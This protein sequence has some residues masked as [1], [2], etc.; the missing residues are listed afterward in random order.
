MV[1][2]SSGCGRFVFKPNQEVNAAQQQV[3]TLTQQNQEY[4]VR[5][6]SLDSD[7]QELESILAQSRQQIQLLN[8][9]LVATRGQLKSSTEQLLAA[10]DQNKQLQGKTSALLAS[11]Q[12]RAGAKIRSNNSLLK[13]LQV[14][15]IPG[16]E[17]RQ[18][19]DVIRVEV[20]A[21]MIFIP[22]SQNMVQGAEQLLQN[23][24]D[25]L[26]RNFPDQIIGIEGHTDNNPP[27][28]HQFSSNHHLS[29]V[30]SLVVY[31]LLVQR[32]SMPT[33]QLFVIGHGANHPIVSNA[34]DV[35][36]KRNRRIEYVVYP[37]RIS[38]R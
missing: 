24:A 30:Q 23:V 17:V 1:L 25:E 28:N 20:P 2:F 21:D 9:E 18:D 7:N 34:T 3:Q 37:E 31:N 32:G 36:K 22:G 38:G 10:R 19:G 8:N 33:A 11:A 6:Q 27:H 4:Q 14:G 5:A 26:R 12:K 35:G 13:N 15:N 16:I 29:V